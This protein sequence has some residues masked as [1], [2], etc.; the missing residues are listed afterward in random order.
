MVSSFFWGGGVPSQFLY[1]TVYAP[2]QLFWYQ[3]QLHLLG[4]GSTL[5][6]HLHCQDTPLCVFSE[7]SFSRY[8]AQGSLHCGLALGPDLQKYSILSVV[9]S[10]LNTSVQPP[11]YLG[12]HTDPMLPICKTILNT[13]ITSFLNG[14]SL[15]ITSST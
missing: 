15:Q 6:L 5:K 14:L 3:V 12:T 11:L 8:K 4:K 10:L 9:S 1:F 13:V 2:H 7:Y